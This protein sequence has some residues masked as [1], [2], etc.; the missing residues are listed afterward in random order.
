MLSTRSIEKIL[1][2]LRRVKRT[3]QKNKLN[4]KDLFRRIVR[5]FIELPF[6]T[7]AHSGASAF[8]VP[9]AIFAHGHALFRLDAGR[10]IRRWL[11]HVSWPASACP[12]CH[13]LAVLTATGADWFTLGVFF[14]V[15]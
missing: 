4:S 6:V 12:G 8:S 14:F 15:A 13:T 7:S 9:T 2:A 5:R 10:A 1:K 3:S 11:N